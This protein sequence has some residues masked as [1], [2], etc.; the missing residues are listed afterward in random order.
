M[1]EEYRA[2]K[3]E[4]L[5]QPSQEGRESNGKVVKE[6]LVEQDER[7]KT[8]ESNNK[9]QGRQ[10]KERVPE[11]NGGQCQRGGWSQGI[12]LLLR[13]LYFIIVAVV[14]DCESFISVC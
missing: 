1:H 10:R 6:H 4:L 12:A 13:G 8:V 3:D 14:G 7:V 11:Q 5:E 2:A 9:S